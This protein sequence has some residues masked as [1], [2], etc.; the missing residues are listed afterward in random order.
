MG[1]EIA[2]TDSPHKASKCTTLRGLLVRKDSPFR[3][4]PIRQKLITIYTDKMEKE[5][6]T[7]MANTSEVDLQCERENE[8]LTKIAEE[9]EYSENVTIDTDAQPPCN[10][11]EDE[12]THSIPAA[13]NARN[14]IKIDNLSVELEI[15]RDSTFPKT[16]EPKS[17]NQ[18]NQDKP[19]ELEDTPSG[20]CPN[21]SIE[22]TD[23]DDSATQEDIFTG[24]NAEHSDYVKA[25]ELN[26]DM[27]TSD[28][29]NTFAINSLDSS[30]TNVTN[31]S[32]IEHSSNKRANSD[33]LEDTVDVGNLT[34]LNCSASS[35]EIFC[36]RLMRTS[37]QAA[38]SM[39]E[40]DTL[41]VTDS[42]FGSLPLS[43]DSQCPS[44]MSVEIS[45]PELLDSERPIYPALVSCKKPITS[46]VE[47]LTNP[48]WVQFLTTYLA[49]RN[50]ES[51]GDLARLS[52]REINRIPVKGN[53]K[54][55]FVK[56]V[57]KC[58]EKTYAKDIDK[59][60]EDSVA[61]QV[62][63]F[64]NTYVFPSAVN[65]ISEDCII[66]SNTDETQSKFTNHG[67]PLGEPCPAKGFNNISLTD[68]SAFSTFSRT[69]DLTL[70]ETSHISA[71]DISSGTMY[72][73]SAA[74]T[75]VSKSS[76]TIP[77]YVSDIMV[78]FTFQC[79]KKLIFAVA[80]F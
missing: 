78:H 77:M 57:F 10:S 44:E 4:K 22:S 69:T 37:T 29:Q 27:D 71:T 66:K 79:H 11:M 63:C 56:G 14:N 31:H 20:K 54:T 9:L 73:S 41:P 64:V 67:V 46:I 40:Q 61:N 32:I 60:T 52:E 45:H 65:V 13:I 58:F 68:K 62:S 49:N 75:S 70:N 38:E 43:Q 24:V 5:D 47:H 7:D 15:T 72:T 28:V 35:D 76:N 2:S 50:I 17:R 12:A 59:T 21:V 18:L 80:I 74:S 39:E 1:Y 19:A 42:V 55:E 48:L 51:V 33:N 36:G 23:F 3:L 30:K 6:E 53:P 26:S 8:L 34:G 16:M 25:A